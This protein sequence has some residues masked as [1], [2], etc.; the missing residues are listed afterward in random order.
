MANGKK[1]PHRSLTGEPSNPNNIPLLETNRYAAGSSGADTGYVQPQWR[2]CPI[3]DGAGTWEND[4]AEG[5]VFKH[6][7]LWIS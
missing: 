6:H 5:D 3:E 7:N 2:P 1:T 4:N